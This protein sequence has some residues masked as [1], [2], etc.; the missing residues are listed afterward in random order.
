MVTP[1]LPPAA[2]RWFGV[3]DRRLPA[4]IP[5]WLD[6]RYVV[7]GATSSRPRHLPWRLWSEQQLQG[8]H[9]STVTMEADEACATLNGVTIRRP[10]ADVDFWEFFLSLRAE[11]KFPDRAPKSLVRSLLRGRVPDEILDRRDKT[12]FDDHALRQIDYAALEKTL[13][14]RG[15]GY[16]MAGVD[17][18]VLRERIRQRQLDLA[19]WVWAKDLARVHAFVSLS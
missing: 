19:D 7:R 14:D 9:G 17:Y 12:V 5:P 4:R 18:T 2:L 1:F 16:R 11:V 15:D 6:P 10:L 3:R 8:F 13:G